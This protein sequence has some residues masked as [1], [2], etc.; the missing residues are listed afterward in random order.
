MDR[1]MLLV[2]RQGTAEETLVLP[3]DALV[4]GLESFLN[5]W[6]LASKFTITEQLMEKAQ[7][8][9]DG[10]E[11]VWPTVKQ[12][13]EG[14]PFSTLLVRIESCILVLDEPPQQPVVE[15]K[16]PVVNA[17]DVPLEALPLP[18]GGITITQITELL[19]AAYDG[20]L[21]A[22]LVQVP[23][24]QRQFRVFLQTLFGCRSGNGADGV[25]LGAPVKNP[26]ADA[27]ADAPGCVGASPQARHWRRAKGSPANC[28][29]R[30]L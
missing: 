27:P 1:P 9:L 19:S 20:D 21:A 15:E 14:T 29:Q 6:E 4:E 24:S 13:M 26:A 25:C 10:N 30:R 5:D 17:L 23:G 12:Q 28:R 18:A 11:W 22:T 2:V 7:L 8:V 16:L 3:D